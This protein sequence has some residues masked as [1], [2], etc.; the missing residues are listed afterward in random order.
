MT[1]WTHMLLQPC[2]LATKKKKSA[3]TGGDDITIPANLLQEASMLGDNEKQH[4]RRPK[5]DEACSSAPSDPRQRP[6]LSM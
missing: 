6:H 4:M 2:P 5:S 1:E 3:D